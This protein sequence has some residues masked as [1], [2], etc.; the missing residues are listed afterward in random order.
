MDVVASALQK[1]LGDSYDPFTDPQLT[2]PFPFFAQARAEPVFYSP[3]LDYWLVTRY[4]DCREVLQNAKI[5]SATNT[6]ETI[7]PLCPHALEAIQSGFHPVKNLTN[8]DPPVHTRT[9]RLANVAFTRS[10]VAQWDGFVRELTQGYLDKFSGG[11]ADIVADLAFQLPALVIFKIMGV[12]PESVPVAKAASATRILFN[13]GFPSD[14]EQIELARDSTAFWAFTAKT[15]A[16][17]A[18]NLGDDFIS[19]LLQ[20][21]DGDL[22][23][24]SEAEITTILSATLTAGHETTT[25]VIGNAF[26][27]LL[28]HRDAWQEICA[29][30]ALIPHA[31]E[32]LLRID[33]AVNSWRRKALVDTEIGGTKIP[34]GAKM[35]VL[36]G[37]ANRDPDVFPDPD[38]LDIHRPNAKEH[39]AFGYGAHICIGAP[40]A[41][42][43]V[44]VVLEEVSKR[45]PSMRLTPGQKLRFLPNTSFRGPRSLRVEWDG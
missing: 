20:A 41:R 38:K 39:I 32:E 6:L 40:L 12:P 43:E 18:K 1:Q 29:D 17:R 37:S 13:W 2:D 16:D 22:P 35:L 19:A 11:S 44:K 45:F 14:E 21:R 7:K 15:V 28:T 27:W 24:L 23:A 9:R 42:L 5:F 3:K 30:P 34:A 4:R 36:I 10:R 31:V 26:H 25:S 33:P 8:A